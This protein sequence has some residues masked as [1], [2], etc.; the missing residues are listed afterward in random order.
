MSNDIDI[1][2]N[3]HMTIEVV[4]ETKDYYVTHR[5]W[6]NTWH[7]WEDMDYRVIDK[8]RAPAFVTIISC[9]ALD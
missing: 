3:K 6:D 7:E 1:E 4:Q 2:T 8:V 9:P 5:I